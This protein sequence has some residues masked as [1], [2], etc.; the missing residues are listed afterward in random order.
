VSP[1]LTV[2]STVR[3]P[4]ATGLLAGRDIDPAATVAGRD[5]GSDSLHLKR[6]RFLPVDPV[7]DGGDSSGALR[8]RVSCRGGRGV[9]RRLRPLVENADRNPAGT[10]AA[11]PPIA[12]LAAISTTA[13]QSG[14]VRACTE[15]LLSL[16]TGQ[17]APSGPTFAGEQLTPADQKHAV[18][19]KK[20]GACS[21]AGARPACSTAATAGATSTSGASA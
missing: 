6:V 5:R 16:L 19:R 10:T 11:W 21:S 17:A 15:Y 9:E 2:T 18:H 14:L 1:A 8:P 20:G 13:S 7:V 4:A 3:D 12:A